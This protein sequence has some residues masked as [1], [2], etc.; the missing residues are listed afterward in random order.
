MN[1]EA[2]ESIPKENAKSFE[3]AY[4]SELAGWR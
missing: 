3:S 2:H 1:S 4:L